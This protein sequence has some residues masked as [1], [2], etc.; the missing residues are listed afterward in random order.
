MSVG[1]FLAGL[2]IASTLTGLITEAIKKMVADTVNEIQRPNILAGV[3][4]V[5]VSIALALGYVAV[6]GYEATATAIVAGVAFVLLSWLC[7]MLGYDKVVQTL[8]QIN[9]TEDKDE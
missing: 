7:A 8:T 2:G 5:V 3:V 1:T 4:S 9:N 6:T